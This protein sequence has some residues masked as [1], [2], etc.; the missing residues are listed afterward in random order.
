MSMSAHREGAY[1]A[2]GQNWQDAAAAAAKKNHMHL[3]ASQ[4][5]GL[6][7]HGIDERSR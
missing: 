4:Q 5:Q 3:R 2:T 7:N 1:P 6:G